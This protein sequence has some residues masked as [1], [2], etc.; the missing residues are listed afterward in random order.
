M[1]ALTL[2]SVERKHAYHEHLHDFSE[3]I[4]RLFMMVILVFF[5]A[6]MAEGSIFHSLTWESC[7]VAIITVLVVRPLSAAIGFIGSPATLD[8]KAVIAAYGIRGL[9]SFYYLAYALGHEEFGQAEAMWATVCV[10]VLLSIILHGVTVTPV[11][12]YIDSRRQD[13]VD[14]E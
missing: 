8:E 3:Q 9:G 13:R 5:G 10:T 7:A 11:M 6:A 14:C 4:E 1:A 2:R 12:Q